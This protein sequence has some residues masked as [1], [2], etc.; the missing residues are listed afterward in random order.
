VSTIDTDAWFQ[1]LGRLHPMVLHLPI[2]LWF[3]IAILEYGGVLL[4][5]Q[6]SRA[7]IA[8]LAWVAALGAAMSATS[9][10]I[11]AMEPDYTASRTLD[12]HRW[13][14]IGVAAVGLLA[15]IFAG[16]RAR[17]GF[18]LLLLFVIVA[19]LPAGHFGSEM[20]H[21]KNFLIEPFHEMRQQPTTTTGQDPTAQGDD[22]GSGGDTRPGGDAGS[23][24]DT[25]SGGDSRPG[26]ETGSGG[27]TEPGSNAG[28]TGDTGSG[29]DPPSA[30]NTDQPAGT[31]TFAEVLPILQRLCGKCHGETKQKSELALNTQQ[32]IERGGE[33]GVVLVPGKPD[34]SPLLTNL[35]LPIDDDYHMPPEGKPQPTAAEI[36]MLRAWIAAGGPFDAND[37]DGAPPGPPPDVPNSDESPS[38]PGTDGAGKSHGPDDVDDATPGSPANTAGIKPRGAPPDDTTQAGSPRVDPSEGESGQRQSPPAAG[39]DQAMQAAITALQSR[40]AHVARV[41]PGAQGLWID[42]AAIAPTLEETEVC[43]L[44]LP[45]LEQV[46]DLGLAR[47]SIGDDTLELCAQMPHLQRLDLRKTRIT[48]QGIAKLREAPSLRELVLA[49]NHLGGET[50]DSLLEMPSLTKVYLWDSGITEA[51]IERLVAR[52]QL[53]V[54]TGQA[55]ATEPLETEEEPRFSNALPPP[56]QAALPAAALA[57]LSPVNGLCPVSG[58]PIDA[59]YVVVHLQRAIGF[60]CQNCPKNFWADPSKYEVVV[61]E[62]AGDKQPE[63]GKKPASTATVKKPD[64]R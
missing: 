60:C 35:L 9:G 61:T 25:G 29:G 14:G 36:A 15:A 16:L 32:A 1:L 45:L 3:G 41:A 34:E 4:R 57:A 52:Q 5:R 49:Q 46:V 20:T 59:R 18:R 56:G 28:S 50:V 42:F 58:N 11:L 8:V 48:D 40:H 62:H 33:N 10:W 63:P 2:G 47:V 24:G 13:L 30:T 19:M 39:Y 44:L 64:G 7:V 17:Q 6:P 26:G 31:A 21:G 23:A 22:T 54:N 38:K 51:D 43:G 37:D 53:T 55:K 12:L 27:D